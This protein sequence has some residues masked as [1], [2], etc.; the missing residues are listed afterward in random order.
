[1]DGSAWERI[2]TGGARLAW[3][4][5]RAV[6]RAIPSR[7]FRPAWAPAPLMQSRERSK[8][9]L[10]W[11][12]D[13]D[14]LCPTCVK[15]TRRRILDGEQDVETLTSRARRRDHGAHPRA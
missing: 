15:E 1:M 7:P 6:A 13:T 10:G 14:S 5:V 11:P 9:T 8:P 3:P 4:V 2:A 12:R